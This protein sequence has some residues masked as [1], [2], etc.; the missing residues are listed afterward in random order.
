MWFLRHLH[1][2]TGKSLSGTSALEKAPISKNCIMGFLVL[3]SLLIPDIPGDSSLI[4]LVICH[5]FT[6]MSTFNTKI[7]VK[8]NAQLFIVFIN[9]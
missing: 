3:F 6:S 1:E 2:D 7:T 9:N 4:L 5:A 8:I